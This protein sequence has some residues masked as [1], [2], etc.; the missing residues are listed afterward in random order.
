MVKEDEQD[1]R[2]AQTVEGLNVAKAAGIV[3]STGAAC[4]D[5][6]IWEDMY[7]VWLIG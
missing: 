6:R 3:F 2:P 5:G 7:V 4:G 1:C